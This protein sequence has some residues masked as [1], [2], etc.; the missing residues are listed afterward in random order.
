VPESVFGV[1][2]KP[3]VVGTLQGVHIE[4]FVNKTIGEKGGEYILNKNGKT[5]KFKYG[6]FNGHDYGQEA[7]QMMRSL[8]FL[9][10]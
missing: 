7:E 5:I 10:R 1:H 6:F 2:Y 8:V 3:I 9:S 4:G